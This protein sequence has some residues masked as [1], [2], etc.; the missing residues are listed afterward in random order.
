MFTH[1]AETPRP[2]NQLSPMREGPSLLCCMNLYSWSVIPS[3]HRIRTRSIDIVVKFY[4][5]TLWLPYGYMDV[6]RCGI[7]LHWCY[8]NENS[9]KK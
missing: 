7:I 4:N 9:H 5:H 6:F 1:D 3:L 2:G 8:S